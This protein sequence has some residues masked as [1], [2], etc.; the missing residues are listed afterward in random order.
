MTKFPISTN[1]MRKYGS[2]ES[3]ATRCMAR[4]MAWTRPYMDCG[5]VCRLCY[6]VLYS[7]TIMVRM[8]RKKHR[9]GDWSGG[10]IQHK[11]FVMSGP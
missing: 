8:P 2:T 7:I 9:L 11:A 10:E 6:S 4:C 3:S 5:H 1:W